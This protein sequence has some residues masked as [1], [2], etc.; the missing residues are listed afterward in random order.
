MKYNLFFSGI[1]ENDDRQVEN[2]ETAIKNFI[3][4]D[5]AVESEIEFQNVLLLLN[6]FVLQ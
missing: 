2:C 3:N 5:L 6:W 1:P 4:K